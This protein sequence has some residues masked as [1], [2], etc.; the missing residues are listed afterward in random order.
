MVKY[1]TF[2]KV[3]VEIV[4]EVK[5]SAHQEKSENACDRKNARR[6]TL[7]QGPRSQDQSPTPEP[8]KN[9]EKADICPRI[10]MVQRNGCR[11]RA[12]CAGGEGERSAQMGV[13]SGL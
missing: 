4:R 3:A 7:G 13:F 6:G 5:R 10:R 11:S 12:K 9:R 1:F 2:P 8:G